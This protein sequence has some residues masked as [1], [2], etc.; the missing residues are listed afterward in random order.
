MRPLKGGRTTHH[1]PTTCHVVRPACYVVPA[2]SLRGR[3]FH[4]SFP[5]NWH[6]KSGGNNRAIEESLLSVT[7]CHRNHK[8]NGENCLMHT[9]EITLTEYVTEPATLLI[10][11]PDPEGEQVLAALLADVEIFAKLDALLITRSLDPYVA[12]M[13][14]RGVPYRPRVWFGTLSWART[15]AI[16]RATMRLERDGFAVRI[17][18]LRRNRVTHV[19]PTLAG[20]R[21]MMDVHHVPPEHIAAG[22]RRT[23]WG[24]ALADELLKTIGAS[25]AGQSLK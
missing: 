11:W 24:S 8:R 20:I 10:R 6:E 23:R 9:D 15:K 5:P 4:G 19:R 22:L 7:W 1:D 21:F 17:V 25:A 14:H 3:H 18:E 2:M 12:S 13:V 16:S